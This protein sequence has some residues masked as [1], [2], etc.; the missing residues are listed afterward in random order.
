MKREREKNERKKTLEN[1]ELTTAVFVYYCVR[2]H[3]TAFELMHDQTS[4]N[5]MNQ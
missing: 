1:Q 2:Y 5:Q 4:R 3:I